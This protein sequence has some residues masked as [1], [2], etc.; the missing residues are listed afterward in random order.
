MDT[1]TIFYK[2]TIMSVVSIVVLFIFSK[3]LGKRQIAELEFM[4]Y[5]IGISIGSIAAEMAVDFNDR[6]IWVYIYAM[7][8]Y[9]IID[10]LFMVISRTMP[11]LKHF[12][13]GQPLTLI[14]NG[15]I[16]YKELSKSKLDVND[17]LALLRNKDFFDIR[18]VECAVLENNGDLSVLPVKD[19]QEEDSYAFI[20]TYLIVDGRIVYS[21]LEKLNK[22]EAWLYEQLGINNKKQLKSILL[23]LFDTSTSEF[24]NYYKE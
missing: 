16:D 7:A 14:K 4:D 19:Y 8:L 1:L 17:M 21:N 13:K 15:K 24:K 22:D 11:A 9:T 23:S 6:P 18:N 12:F 2:I 3:M 20:P 5:I 10:L